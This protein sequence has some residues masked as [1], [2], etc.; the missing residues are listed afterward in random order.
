MNQYEEAVRLQNEYHDEQARL[1][2]VIAMHAFVKSLHFVNDHRRPKP[3][4]PEGY[5]R[6]GEVSRRVMYAFTAAMARSD[7]KRAL[8]MSEN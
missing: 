7:F 1:A 4:L 2:G 8:S 6:P 5:D 3:G